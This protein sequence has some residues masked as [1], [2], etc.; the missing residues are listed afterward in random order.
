MAATE[1]PALAERLRKDPLAAAADH[2]VTLSPTERAMVVSM[3]PAHLKSILDVMSATGVQ[4]P[5]EPA[6]DEVTFGIREDAPPDNLMVSTGIRTDTPPRSEMLITGMRSDR[7]GP[8]KGIRPGRVAVA[9]AATATVIGVG[10]TFVASAGSRP[11]RPAK[12]APKSM[13][14]AG[15]PDT[16]VDAAATRAPGPQDTD[17]PKPTPK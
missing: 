12:T 5:H 2:G 17:L 6:V 9:V 3:D 13:P 15:A 11:R 7:G 10:V 16:G 1:D 14:D 4:L 8:V